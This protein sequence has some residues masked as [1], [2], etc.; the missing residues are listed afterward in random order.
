M[1]TT[2]VQNLKAIMEDIV[3]KTKMKAILV[4]NQCVSVGSTIKGAMKMILAFQPEIVVSL[5]S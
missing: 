2:S 3:R 4:E 5:L 1:I